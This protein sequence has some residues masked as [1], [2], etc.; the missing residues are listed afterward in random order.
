MRLPWEGKNLGKQ[1]HTIWLIYINAGS[2]VIILIIKLFPLVIMVTD[3]KL[4]KTGDNCNIQMGC[5]EVP[6]VDVDKRNISGT[7]MW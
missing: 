1:V 2:G 5:R 6:Y 7:Y 3:I 4:S